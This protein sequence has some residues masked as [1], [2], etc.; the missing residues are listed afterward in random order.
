MLLKVEYLKMLDTFLAIIENF[1]NFNS[2]RNLLYTSLGG[3]SIF[4]LA[5][6]KK[7]SA[8][9]VGNNQKNLALASKQEL[10]NSDKFDKWLKADNSAINNLKNKIK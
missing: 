7:A 3:I 5:N 1:N 2:R 8:Y 4:E 10:E 9:T 6:A